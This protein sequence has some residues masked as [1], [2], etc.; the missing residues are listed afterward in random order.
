MQLL[1]ETRI[2]QILIA[3]LQKLSHNNNMMACF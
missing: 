1:F 3:Y 2:E